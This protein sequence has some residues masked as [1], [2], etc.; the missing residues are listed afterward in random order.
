MPSWINL[1]RKCH[2][3]RADQF[4]LDHRMSS[5]LMKRWVTVSLVQLMTVFSQAKMLEFMRT[6]GRSTSTPG[7]L[8]GTKFNTQRYKSEICQRFIETGVCKFGDKC[9]FAH[10][11][12]ELRVIA[13]HPK[14]K[15]IPCKTF[16]QSGN[17][18]ASHANTHANSG[19]CSYGNRCNFR[20]AESEDD[21][22]KQKLF[23]KRRMSVP[24]VLPVSW[25]RASLGCV[26]RR[27][28]ILY[29]FRHLPTYR[30]QLKANDCQF[31]DDYHYPIE[32]PNHINILLFTCSIQPRIKTTM[33]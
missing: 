15:T 6:R 10:G 33:I 27:K 25:T 32:Y 7:P 18:H 12:E 20:H 13:K 24:S 9:Q 22:M 21:I 2:P 31:F 4:H 30:L 17:T 16:H 5:T 26:K 1:I 3:I 29:Y 8:Y 19:V 14:F 28:L 11:Q 23:V